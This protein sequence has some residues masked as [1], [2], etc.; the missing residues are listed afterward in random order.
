M[1][2]LEAAAGASAK[3]LPDL[4]AP[5]ASVARRAPKRSVA[6]THLSSATTVVP[7]RRH[8]ETQ[9]PAGSPTLACVRVAGLDRQPPDIAAVI[10]QMRR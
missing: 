3:E 8:A 5:Y 9:V 10:R 6:V 4:S 7:L 1:N 2:D